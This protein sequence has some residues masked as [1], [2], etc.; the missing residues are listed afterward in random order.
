MLLTTTSRYAQPGTAVP[1]GML[2]G[3]LQNG[4]VNSVQSFAY[5]LTDINGCAID[6]PQAPTLKYVDQIG[7]KQR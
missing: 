7:L 5:S 4:Q 2:P 6:R 3:I 1:A